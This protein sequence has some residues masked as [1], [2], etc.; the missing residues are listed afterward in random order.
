[1]PGMDS[2]PIILHLADG[3]LVV[4]EVD[5]AGQLVETRVAP[6]GTTTVDIV[7]RLQ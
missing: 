3:T 5:G 2:A 7:P 4:L 6:D 1:M